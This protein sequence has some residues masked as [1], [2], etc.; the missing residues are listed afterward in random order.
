MYEPLYTIRNFREYSP[1]ISKMALEISNM[2]LEILKMFLVESWEPFKNL[3]SGPDIKTSNSCRKL[4]FR[5]KN[6]ISFRNQYNAKRFLVVVFNLILISV[7]TI[8]A[9]RA[10]YSMSLAN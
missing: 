5:Q 4:I 9:A 2:A 10:Q 7:A 1:E 3:F 8:V 6:L